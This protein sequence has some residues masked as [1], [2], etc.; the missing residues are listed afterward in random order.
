MRYILV[1]MDRSGC[2]YEGDMPN[3]GVQYFEHLSD[4]KTF[5]KQLGGD[6][7]TY[8]IIEVVSGQVVVSSEY[9]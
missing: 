1:Y 5:V 7:W 4:L 2:Y 6:M 8:R 3:L 9:V